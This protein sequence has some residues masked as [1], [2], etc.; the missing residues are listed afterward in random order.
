MTPSPH[1]FVHGAETWHLISRALV[2]SDR[3]D[4]GVARSS[5]ETKSHGSEMCDDD[6]AEDRKL[7][8]GDGDGKETEIFLAKVETVGSQKTVRK[9]V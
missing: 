7:D 1:G 4:S 9:L 3:W 8:V 5:G 6:G 2:A